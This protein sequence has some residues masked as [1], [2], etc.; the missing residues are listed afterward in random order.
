MLGVRREDVTEAAGKLHGLGVIEYGSGRITVV[1]R[2]KLETLS[3]ECYAV[4]K[5][6]TDR[7]L[8]YLSPAAVRQ[9]DWAFRPIDS[10]TL[11]GL[12]A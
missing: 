3:C 2:S 1:D 11:A 6:E 4:V 7:L 8:L 5:K 10:V 9:K 12:I